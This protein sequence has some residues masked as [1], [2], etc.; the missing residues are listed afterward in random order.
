M[1]I[2]KLV[3]LGVI[4]NAFPAAAKRSR[5]RIGNGQREIKGGGGVRRC[6]AGSEDVFR[7]EGGTRL[8]RRSAAEVALHIADLAEGNAGSTAG[9]KQQRRQQAKK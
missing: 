1:Q 3:R 2:F 6:P 5:A 8:I 7:N 9:G 4:D